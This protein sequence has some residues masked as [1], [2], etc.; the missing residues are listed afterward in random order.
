MLSAA[1][2]VAPC[3]TNCGIC[4]AYLRTKKSCS[5]CRGDNADKSPY[6]LRCIIR[7]CETVK[8][9]HTGFCFECTEYPC[10]RLRALDKR[11]RTRYAMSMLDNLGKIKEVGVEAFV[12]NERERWRCGK[13]SGV[14]NVHRGRC[15]KCGEPMPR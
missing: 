6:I 10:R 13:C 12:R 15:S 5:G 4:S 3:G 14:I 11:Y 2:L 8:S 9:N 7:N 1:R